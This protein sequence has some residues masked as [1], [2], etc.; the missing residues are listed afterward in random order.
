MELDCNRFDSILFEQH[1]DPIA[2]VDKNGDCVKINGS[3]ANYFNVSAAQIRGKSLASVI[4]RDDLGA[5]WRDVE[6]SD[7]IQE[8][9]FHRDGKRGFSTVKLRFLPVVVEQTV[10]AFYA[11]ILDVTEYD[12]LVKDYMD[13]KRIL[14]LIETNASDIITIIDRQGIVNYVSESYATIFGRPHTEIIDRHVLEFVHPDDIPYMEER[15]SES[16]S[17]YIYWLPIEFRYLHA[18][19]RWVYT[20][21]RATPVMTNEE[22]GQLMLFARDISQRKNQ[23]ELIHRMAYHDALTGLPNRLYLREK[24]E[25][26][27]KQSPEDENLGLMFIDLDGFKQVNDTQGHLI[28]DLLLQQVAERLAHGLQKKGFLARMGGDEFVILLDSLESVKNYI[29]IA[30]EMIDL[31]AE[32]FWICKSYIQLTTSIGISLYPMHGRTVEELIHTA[33]TALYWAKNQGKN[34]YA[35]YSLR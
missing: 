15:L 33:D 34:G 5:V 35:L 30:K 26:R 8:F 31:I 14:N 28:G 23:E 13:A 21:V 6:H 3:F 4:E 7:V 32:P 24:L 27:L 20:D 19:G 2:L 10:E 11:L 1:P 22:I 17:G 16:F 9:T 29:K 25:N 18:D 12:L